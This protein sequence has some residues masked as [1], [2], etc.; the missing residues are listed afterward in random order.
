MHCTANRFEQ[1]FGD[2]RVDRVRRIDLHVYHL[3]IKLR[4]G[5][6]VEIET[7]RHVGY[8]LKTDLRRR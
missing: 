3:R 1:V 4:S 2:T 8:R 7:I 5:V 6:G